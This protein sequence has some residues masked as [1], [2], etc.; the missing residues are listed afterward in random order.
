M[1]YV[2]DPELVKKITT[3]DFDSF[4]NHDTTFAHADKLFGRT[5]IMLEDKKWK[6]MRSTMSPIFTSSKMKMMFGLLA[7]QARDFVLFF[8]E[9][10]KKGEVLVVDSSDIFSRFTADGISTSVLGFEADCVRNKESEIFK[11]AKNFVNEFF[12][13][14]GTL[15]ATFSLVL[16]K[17]YEISGLQLTSKSTYNFFKRVVVDKMDERD[18]NNTS[19]PDIIQLLLQL[20]KGQLT[21]DKETDVNDKELANFSANVEYDLDSKDSKAFNFTN[22]D[23]ISQGAIFFGAG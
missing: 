7:D 9:K 20:R 17:L 6:N 2:T 10:A 11:L 18:R 13:D 1:F 3:K 12:G 8:E 15:K 22:D 19:R 4:V 14:L 21:N 16:P 23:W 5:L